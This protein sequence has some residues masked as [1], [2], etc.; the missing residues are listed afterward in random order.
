MAINVCRLMYTNFIS[1]N[2]IIAIFLCIHN[3]D[4]TEDKNGKIGSAIPDWLTSDRNVAVLLIVIIVGFI[5][6][7]N[8][9]V[10]ISLVLTFDSQFI[11]RNIIIV[12]A[13]T[14]LSNF[15][16]VKRT[17]LAIV[18]AVSPVV[19]RTALT[20]TTAINPVIEKMYL[21]VVTTTHPVV[22]RTALIIVTPVSLI[23]MKICSTI[24]IAM[25]YVVRK[26]FIIITISN[27]L[28]GLSNESN[29]SFTSNTFIALHFFAII[30][31]TTRYLHF[32]KS[33]I[34]YALFSTICI[35]IFTWYEYN[36]TVTS[37]VVFSFI[38]LLFGLCFS[39]LSDLHSHNLI[40]C[41]VVALSTA[42][43]ICN[44]VSSFFE[45]AHYISEPLLNFCIVTSIFFEII[46][47]ATRYDT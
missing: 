18:T 47:Y 20:I 23:V 25:N 37:A 7:C 11:D 43:F 30:I 24:I 4:A 15:C 3:V 19:K 13:I 16:L 45:I 29:S 38:I 36:T 46:Y 28:A 12:P 40:L 17:A 32:T 21:T 42:I 10:K 22:K 41:T 8:F 35:I 9:I 39:V 2:A 5:L 31:L 14:G 44:S 6:L 34:Y 1:Q 27:S 26:P 33:V